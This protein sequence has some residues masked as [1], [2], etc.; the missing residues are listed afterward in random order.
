[1]ELT[2]DSTTSAGLDLGTVL[3]VPE[4]LMTSESTELELDPVASI[5]PELEVELTVVVVPTVVPTA[6]TT[7]TL[8]DGA[9]EVDEVLT[10]GSTVPGRVGRE[11]DPCLARFSSAS[12][13]DVEST[14][15][16]DFE[17]FPSISAHPNIK[18]HRRERIMG[19]I[20]L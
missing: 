3:V 1:M 16:A 8:D 20:R 9:G 6:P 17:E 10:T 11:G 12:A 15:A 5:V 4:L 14:S 18:A 2:F 13:S 7:G 19:L